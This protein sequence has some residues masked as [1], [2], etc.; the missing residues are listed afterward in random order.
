MKT[1]VCGCAHCKLANNA[2]HDAQMRLYPLPCEPFDVVF[3]DL[4]SPGNV[5]DKDRNYKVLT[6][7]DCMTGFTMAA[8]LGKFIDSSVVLATAASMAAHG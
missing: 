4:R 2:G 1:A 5:P 6:M 8:Y 7:I 3:P